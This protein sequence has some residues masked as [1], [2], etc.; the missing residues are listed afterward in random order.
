M[1]LGK[2]VNK[3]Q[4]PVP[5]QLDAFSMVY[6]VESPMAGSVVLAVLNACPGMI[7]FMREWWPLTM[8]CA[9]ATPLQLCESGNWKTSL[10]STP[11]WLESEPARSPKRVRWSGVRAE[12]PAA[13]GTMANF[14]W[15]FR[16]P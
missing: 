12:D 4:V 7:S 15:I 3:L 16:S 8:N 5:G 2:I 1:P 9:G 14:G 11:G 6:S 10:A 13:G